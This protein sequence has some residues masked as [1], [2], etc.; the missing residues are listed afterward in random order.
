MSARWLAERCCGDGPRQTDASIQIPPLDTAR[1][2]IRRA[3]GLKT[4][5]PRPAKG[6]PHTRGTKTL[7]DPAGI[8]RGNEWCITRSCG[9]FCRCSTRRVLVV[10]GSAAIPPGVGHYA[11]CNSGTTVRVVGGCQSDTC[12]CVWS[13]DRCYDT[14]GVPSAPSVRRSA[15]LPGGNHGP[16]RTVC[17][18]TI[19][20]DRCEHVARGGWQGGAAT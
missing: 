16:R 6:S 18:R 17:G 10:G 3:R 9:C 5:T 7:L 2:R 13:S 4:T 19:G 8:R 20:G 14:S 1:T 15:K 12:S 11:R